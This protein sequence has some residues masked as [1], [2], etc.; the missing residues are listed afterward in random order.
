MLPLTCRAVI[1]S[2]VLI[3][4]A[5]NR[6]VPSVDL[7][8]VEAEWEQLFEPRV[9]VF[10]LAELRIRV[11][12]ALHQIELRT[13][14]RSFG[15]D[16]AAQQTAPLHREVHAIR[17]EERHWPRCAGLHDLDIV[18]AVCAAPEMNVDVAD[19]AVVGI[20][21]RQLSLA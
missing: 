20:E 13:E 9:P 19:M 12:P 10:S 8:G 17:A 14:E 16:R 11:A 7:D 21:R 15:N 4:G 2:R 6:T 3:P 5:R 1:A 18:D